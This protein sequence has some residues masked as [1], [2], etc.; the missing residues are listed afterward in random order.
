MI[1]PD[2]WAEAKVRKQVEGR[3]VTVKRFGWSD[4]NQDEARQHA[5][6]RAAEAM[7]RI[8]SG[9]KLHRADR[10][11][12]YGGA[13]GLPIREEVVA[14]HD[15]VVISRN[16]YGAL[17]LNTP[18]VLFADIDFE[19][20]PGT[21]IF[22]PVTILHT[23]IAAAV[24]YLLASWWILLVAF[25]A[26]LTLSP[27]TATAIFRIVAV[28]TGGP[29]AQA[30]KRLDAFV[31]A[32]PEWRLRVYRT[33]AGL[34]LLA[35]HQTFNPNGDEAQDF[36]QAIHSDPIYV[37]MCKNQHCFRARV[38]PKPWRIGIPSHMKPRPG[39]WPVKPER[40][41]ARQDWI[42]NYERIA[43]DFAACRF[44][45][46]LGSGEVDYRVDAVRQLH[47]RYARADSGLPI[48]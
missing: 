19:T 39:V 22:L 43:Q 18:D 34:R 42:D 33:P 21:G 48:A 4:M 9:E 37:R 17:C 6:E 46:D 31:Q 5:E 29:E 15:D 12:A 8:E 23:A 1:V 20:N 47:D 35:M 2:Y 14:R 16:A 13:D 44:E 3:Q 11:V 32:H 24:G 40:M 7:A 10:K 27:V 41:A 28:F 25:I 36:F 26:G 30:R 38:S 45:G